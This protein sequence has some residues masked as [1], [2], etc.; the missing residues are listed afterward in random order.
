M[1]VCPNFIAKQTVG[2]NELDIVIKK[3]T[4]LKNLIIQSFALLFNNYLLKKTILQLR[5]IERSL[6][7]EKKQQI[8]TKWSN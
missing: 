8:A 3:K 4:F 5:E 7:K 1:T 6:T 2:L